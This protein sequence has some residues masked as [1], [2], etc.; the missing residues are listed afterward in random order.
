[1][2]GGIGPRGP[3]ESPGGIGIGGRPEETVIGTRIVGSIAS[4]VEISIAGLVAC[5]SFSLSVTATCT[6]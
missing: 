4:L 5:A 1:M 2:G 3:P 6:S